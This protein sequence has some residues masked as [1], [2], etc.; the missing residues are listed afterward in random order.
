M[1]VSSKIYCQALVLATFMDSKEGFYL[2]LPLP[3][4]LF[5]NLSSRNNSFTGEDCHYYQ[6]TFQR[7]FPL[8]LSPPIHKVSASAVPLVILGSVSN[9]AKTKSIQPH[10]A[11]EGVVK[12]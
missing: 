6:M 10:S 4:L 5:W 2:L 7:I 12:N 8:S 11:K 3:L 9:T 1:C